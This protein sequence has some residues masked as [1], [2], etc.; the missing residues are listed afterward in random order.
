MVKVTKAYLDLKALAVHYT[1]QGVDVTTT[2]AHY[3]EILS[4]I[5]EGNYQAANDLITTSS[6]NLGKLYLAKKQAESDAEAARVKAEADAEAKR[7]ILSGVVSGGSTPLSGVNLTLLQNGQ[8]VLTSTTDS[9]GAFSIKTTADTYSLKAELVGYQSTTQDSI[10]I[11]AQQ[12][13][14][15]NIA[16]TKIPVATPIPT[17]KPTAKP[18]AKPTT[19]PAPTAFPVTTSDS[20]AYS[21]YQH[22]TIQTSQGS[23][24]ADIMTFDLASGHIKVM[25][26]TA[27]DNDCTNNCPVKSV[28]SYVQQDGG[29]AGMNGSYFCPTAYAD[30]AG[31]TNSFYWK[32]WN[33]RLQ[34]M[35]NA[36]N[37]LGEWDPFIIFE[38]N[39]HA[40]FFQHWNSFAFTSIPIYAGISCRPILVL[41]GQYVVSDSELDNKQLTAKISRTAMGLRGQTFYIAV[42]QGATVPDLG[43]VAVAMGLDNAMNTDAGGSTGMIYKGQYKLGPGRAV[44]N[45]IIFVEQ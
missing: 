15:K 12:T 29:F 28:L 41:S 16:L 1:E 31:K 42:I 3:Q 19:K 35:I 36:N 40:T 25:V 18:T 32:Q 44:P 6:A 26:D 10:Q 13:L 9:V 24:T 17:S 11:V 30:C 23:F 2:A 39:G 8:T 34:K 21:T 33:S 14:T 45:A 27:D 43:R 22:T 4:L 37:T 38:A 5:S 7:G 20:T